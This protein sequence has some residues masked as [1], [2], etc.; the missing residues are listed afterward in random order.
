MIDGLISNGYNAMIRE[1]HFDVV[2]REYVYEIR[3][4]DSGITFSIDKGEFHGCKKCKERIKRDK[5][6]VEG[7]EKCGRGIGKPVLNSHENDCGLRPDKCNDKC[8][9]PAGRGDGENR[10]LQIT[11]GNAYRRDAGKEAT[12][13]GEIRKDR[14]EILADSF[15]ELLF[16][17]HD[18]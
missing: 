11:L 13:L 9:E 14:A 1:A 16:Q 5:G 12:L 18:T 3:E 2:E 15:T 7:P 4:F 6:I 17:K 10:R 8:E